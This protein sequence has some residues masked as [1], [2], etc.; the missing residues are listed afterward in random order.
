MTAEAVIARYND[1]VE[2]LRALATRYD[3]R[4]R[5]LR[6]RRAFCAAA[7]KLGYLWLDV[8]VGWRKNLDDIDVLL[9]ALD[10]ALARDDRLTL[11]AMPERFS[12]AASGSLPMPIVHRREEVERERRQQLGWAC[13]IWQA[14]AI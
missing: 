13:T 7:N 4:F 12:I 3:T 10:R 2:R 1:E 11:R 14:T 9:D 8:V 5:H 6:A